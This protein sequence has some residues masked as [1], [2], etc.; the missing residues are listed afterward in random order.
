MDTTPVSPTRR[1]SR[2]LIL[3]IIEDHVQAP[4]NVQTL[5]KGDVLELR[6]LFRQAFP[7]GS[8]KGWC[9][10]VWCQEVRAALGYPV[11][12]AKRY[13]R[14]VK[15]H[16]HRVIPAMRDWAEECGILA[17]PDASVEMEDSTSD[18]AL[19]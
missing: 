6:K 4:L 15:H 9:Y 18:F 14:P 1:E 19:Q 5:P 11:R 7:Y 17:D 3:G 12:K 16:S 8:R 2:K 13:E 10:R